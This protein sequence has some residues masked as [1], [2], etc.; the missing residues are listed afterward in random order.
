MK[1]F[2]MLIMLIIVTSLVLT[3]CSPPGTAEPTEAMVEPT[4]ASEPTKAPEP[5]TPPEPTGLVCENGVKV[6]LITDATGPL[7]IYG[8][9]ILRSFMLGMEYVAGAPGS[10]GEVFDFA[11]GNSNTFMIDDCEVEVI[12]GDDQ[13]NPENTASIAREMIEVEGVNVLVGTVSS[14]ATAT[15]QQIAA[16][17]QIPDPPDRCPGCCQ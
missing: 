9:H 6:G 15:L 1:T 7:A 16:E 5:T 10:V 13:S 8:A 3:A 17:N 11:A 4:S 2:R 14:G 12:V